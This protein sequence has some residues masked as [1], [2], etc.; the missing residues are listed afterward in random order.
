MNVEKKILNY[1][2]L[3][4]TITRNIPVVEGKAY[5]DDEIYLDFN[6]WRNCVFNDCNIIIDY[7]I[8]KLVDNEFNGCKFIT[9]IGSPA[10][11]ILKIDHLIR[12]Q[13]SN[14]L[15]EHR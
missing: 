5:S 12:N 14:E 11:A 15:E 6:H 13:G 9:D 7:G 3:S 4:K 2:Q 1:I 10:G 8:L